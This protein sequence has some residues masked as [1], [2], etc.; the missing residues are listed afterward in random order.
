MN[1]TYTGGIGSFLLSCMILSFLQQKQ[2]IS[3]YGD[4]YPS[5]NLGALLLEFLNLYGTCFNY[6][7]TGIS[8]REDGSYFPKFTFNND[9]YTS[10]LSKR[11]KKKMLLMKMKGHKKYTSI[12]DNDEDDEKAEKLL[13]SK[14]KEG[15]KER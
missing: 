5:W 14:E 13:K 11:K 6:Y 9:S 1:D 12:D 3:F 10:S 15:N 2:K 8:V 7:M 4:F